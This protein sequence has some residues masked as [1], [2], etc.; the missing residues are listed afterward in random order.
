MKPT[1]ITHM[2][3]RMIKYSE[4]MVK[5]NLSTVRKYITIIIYISL[6]QHQNIFVNN[7]N[8]HKKSTKI[9]CFSNKLNENSR[10]PC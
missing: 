10:L 1:A 8:R 6:E 7:N 9:K 4:L 2:E 5:E 3:L